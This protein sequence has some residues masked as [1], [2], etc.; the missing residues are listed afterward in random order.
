MT[1]GTNTGGD[2]PPCIDPNLLKRCGFA[3]TGQGKGLSHWADSLV[4][5]EKKSTRLLELHLFSPN[6]LHGACWIPALG[7]AVPAFGA[8]EAGKE[9]VDT[10]G[11]RTPAG[12]LS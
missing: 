4:R 5:Q 1:P 11:S 12:H 6:L 7:R 3:N 9:I 8:R 10:R 2:V